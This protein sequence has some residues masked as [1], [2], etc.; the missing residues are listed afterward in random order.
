M[1]VYFLTLDLLILI[2]G[3]NSKF[4]F[5]DEVLGLK[6]SLLIGFKTDDL[7]DDDYISRSIFS[8]SSSLNLI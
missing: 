1:G 7:F 4:R 3:F 2:I 8:F 6:L 5:L